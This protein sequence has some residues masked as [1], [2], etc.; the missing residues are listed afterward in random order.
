MDAFH[1]HF[2]SLSLPSL[3]IGSDDMEYWRM[4]I[5]QCRHTSTVMSKTAIEMKRERD[6]QNVEERYSRT[7]EKEYYI[8]S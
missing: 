8:M 6:K 5:G 2:G 1:R 7:K 3:C 4:D